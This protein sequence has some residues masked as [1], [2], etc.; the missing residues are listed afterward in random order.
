MNCNINDTQSDIIEELIHVETDAIVLHESVSK[1][2]K[3][4]QMLGNDQNEDVTQTKVQF[5]PSPHSL[6]KIECTL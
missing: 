1:P 6:R 4:N 3:P 2:D 5:E